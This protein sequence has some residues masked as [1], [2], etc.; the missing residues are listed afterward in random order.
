MCGGLPSPCQPGP[1]H[2]KA[3]LTIAA[4][5]LPLVFKHPTTQEPDMEVIAG[6]APFVRIAL[7]AFSGWLFAADPE[8]VEMIR[9]PDVVAAVTAG[10]SLL[11]WR[12]AVYY[13]WHT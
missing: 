12:V 4:R 9:H 13:G 2:G 3:F 7:Y 1:S 8:T 11:W 5:L 6:L 10:L